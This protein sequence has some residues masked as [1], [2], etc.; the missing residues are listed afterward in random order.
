M[1]TEKIALSVTEIRPADLGETRTHISRA[2]SSMQ[3]TLF[4]PATTDQNRNDQS[5]SLCGWVRAGAV[6][7]R[8]SGGS[9]RRVG[10]E[11][12]ASWGNL[13]ARQAA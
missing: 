11:H 4:D 10:M 1:T 13:A 12:T 7:R 3:S 6:R 2:P 8:G 9:G 5:P